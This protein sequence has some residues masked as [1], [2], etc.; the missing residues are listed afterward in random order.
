MWLL[1]ALAT[2]PRPPWPPP[3]RPCCLQVDEE[4]SLR[5]PGPARHQPA[6]EEPTLR[7][8][9]AEVEGEEDQ[10]QVSPAPPPKTF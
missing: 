6:P 3:D 1:Q 4:A 2:P 10:L 7:S 9:G 5:R 8:D